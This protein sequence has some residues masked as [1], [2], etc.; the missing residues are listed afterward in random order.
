MV[1]LAFLSPCEIFWQMQLCK[2]SSWHKREESPFT[3]TSAVTASMP[4]VTLSIVTKKRHHQMEQCYDIEKRA[5]SG[6]WSDWI[7]R[8]HVAERLFSWLSVCAVFLQGNYS[9]LSFSYNTLDPSLIL[10]HLKTISPGEGLTFSADHFSWQ[11]SAY[12]LAN[13][14]SFSGRAILEEQIDN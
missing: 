9:V 4:T 1:L 7:F 13:C 10:Q 11:C 3:E 6:Y 5:T 14:S 2:L 8:F 12:L